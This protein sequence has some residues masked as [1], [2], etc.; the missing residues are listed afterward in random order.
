MVAMRH[1]AGVV[2]DFEEMPAAGQRDYL[3]FLAAANRRFDTARLERVDGGA[4]RR[5]ELEPRRLCPCRRQGL[6]DALRR[7]LERRRSRA[8]RLAGLVRPASCARRCARSAPTRRSRPS[9]I[10]ATIGRRAS[11]PTELTVEEAWLSAHDSEADAALR[12]GQRQCRPS[13]MRRDGRPTTSG[14]S[15]RRAPGTSFAPPMS[16]ASPEVALW[17]LGSEDPGIW[18][19]FRRLR[20]TASCPTSRPAPRRGRRRRGSGEILRIEARRPTARAPITTDRLG[21]IRDE[22]YPHPADALC[23]CDGPATGP[24]WSR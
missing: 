12:S 15:T 14:C 8:D 21:L 13:T 3:R 11:R 24:A 16:S 20:V 2:F 22:K 7:A 5:S 18:T 6:P 17:H 19:R 1:G 10:T 9:P 23:R 4:G